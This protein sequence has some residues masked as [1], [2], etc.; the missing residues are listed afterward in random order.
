MNDARKLI[1]PVPIPKLIFTDEARE[2]NS[3][4]IQ[5]FLLLSNAVQYY[6]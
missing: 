5:P 2:T 4:P 1:S 3:L 6:L